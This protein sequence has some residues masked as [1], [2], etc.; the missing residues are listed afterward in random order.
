MAVGYVNR[1]T[2]CVIRTSLWE[3]KI[4]FLL[5]SG[6]YQKNNLEINFPLCRRLSQK[7]IPAED[8]MRIRKSN[9]HLVFLCTGTVRLSV[10]GDTPMGTRRNVRR[11][12]QGQ[13]T[14]CRSKGP[15]SKAERWHCEA[16][17]GPSAMPTTRS[18]SV[19]HYALLLFFVRKGESWVKNVGNG[20][21]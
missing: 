4:Y 7:W 1:D 9:F 10:A 2:E 5:R 16:G 17:T 3:P 15:R 21:G 6:C 11:T 8:I 19:P 18:V 14:T 20:R 13:G 12:F